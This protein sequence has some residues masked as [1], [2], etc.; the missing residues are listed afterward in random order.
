MRIDATIQARMGSTRL[1]GKVLAHAAGKPLLELQVERIRR[2]WLIDRVIIATTELPADDAIEA[3]AETMGVAC[4]RGS[5]DDVLGRVTSALRTFDVDLHVEF[6]GDSPLPDSFLIDAMIGVYLKHAGDVDYVTN[7]L[8]TTFPPGQEV[9]VYRAATLFEAEKLVEDDS[10]REHVGIHIYR[11][12]DRFRIHNVEAP[13]GLR[14]PELHLEVDT[15]AD[16]EVI[17]RIYDHFYSRDP[18][19]GLREI[20]EF[21]SEVGL[22]ELNRNEPRR[23]R[24][25][26]QD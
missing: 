7:A 17:R 12:P 25:F 10:L 6:Q 3:L 18:E 22:D 9:S 19:F 21:A 20:L 23:W 4:F 16:L 8:K 2:S 5:V 11:R 13:A 24:E 26:R 1:P 14:V 15:A